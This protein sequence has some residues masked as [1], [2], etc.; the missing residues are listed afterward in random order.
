MNNDKVM[1]ER[2]WEAELTRWTKVY[3]HMVHSDRITADIGIFILKVVLFISCGGVLALLAAF[4]FVLTNA[5]GASGIVLAGKYLLLAIFLGVLGT[6]SAFF[7]QGN[8]TAILWDDLKQ[9]HLKLE[10]P[11]ARLAQKRLMTFTIIM[12]TASVLIFCYAAITALEA[13]SI[14]IPPLEDVL[15]Y[16]Y[17]E[18]M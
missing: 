4:P 13:I 12:L 8:I 14:S 3:E 10:Y 7:R 18:Y 9:P 16:I 17:E 6:V 2:A 15:P 11:N 5:E 1:G